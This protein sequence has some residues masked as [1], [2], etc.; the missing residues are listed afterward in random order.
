MFDDLEAQCFEDV[1][2]A[3]H[4]FIESLKSDVAGQ[5]RDL[6]LAKNAAL[7]LFHLREHA[8]WAK[9]RSWPV[10]LSACPEYVVLQ[11][12][13]NVFKHGP[14]RNGQV[15]SPTVISHRVRGC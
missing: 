12:V 2:R 8:P 9:G 13:V 4:A 1:L 15:A 6:R 5:S 3:Y 11:D 14:R 10:F 7:A